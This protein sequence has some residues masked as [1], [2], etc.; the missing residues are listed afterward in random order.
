MKEEINYPNEAFGHCDVGTAE[1]TC[2]NCP[3]YPNECAYM[4]MTE[5]DGWTIKSIS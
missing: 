1:K 3:N 2:K 4:E 5:E